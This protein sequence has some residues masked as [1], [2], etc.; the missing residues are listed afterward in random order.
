MQI[1]IKLDDKEVKK[2]LG[3]LQTGLKSYKT[4]LET[5][6]TTLIDI[7]G[8]KVFKT[9]GKE[10]GSPWKG[11]SASTLEARARRSGYYSNPPKERGKIL[12]W[13]GRLQ[14]SFRKKAEA[15]RLTIDNTDKK[16]KH[17]QLGSGRTPQRPMLGITK[18]ITSKI[19][20]SLNDYIKKLIK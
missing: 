1:S 17:H 20:D 6:G 12:I 15:L 16:F 14:E 13:T 8:N 10:L 19:V 2:K 18:D 3:N 7:Y 9:Q 4:P 5:I 11:L